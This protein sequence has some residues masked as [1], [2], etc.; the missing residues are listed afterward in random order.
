MNEEQAARKAKARSLGKDGYVLLGSYAVPEEVLKGNNLRML[1]ACSPA[2]SGRSSP[3][4]G[5]SPRPHSAR[6]GGGGGATLSPRSAL[7]GKPDRLEELLSSWGVAASCGA[8]NGSPAAALPP[9]EYT[10]LMRDWRTG[11]WV[12]E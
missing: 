3:S 12:V 8:N 2:G 1:R 6:D 5:G 4:G 11:R 9:P 7:S 10:V